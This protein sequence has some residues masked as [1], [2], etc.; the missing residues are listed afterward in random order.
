MSHV[1]SQFVE[2]KFNVVSCAN[3]GVKFAVNQDLYRQ[4]VVESRRSVYCPA[5]GLETVWRESESQRE[6]RRLKGELETAG[7]RADTAARRAELA[8]AR[9]TGLENSLRATKGVVTK[10][11]R[12]ISNGVCPCCN[13]TFRDLHRHMASQHPEFNGKG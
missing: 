5:C 10:I 3:C 9:A 6:I 7:R 12:R 4:A 1:F 8:D 13:R 11:K 2:T